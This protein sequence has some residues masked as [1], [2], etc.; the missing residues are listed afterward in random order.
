MRSK[1][2]SMVGFL[3][4]LSTLTGCCMGITGSGFVE[5]ESREVSGFSSI[6]FESAGKMTVRQT[7]K[8]SLIISADDNI[9]PLL[10]S[11]VVGRTLYL[12]STGVTN[13]RPTETIEFTV[14]VENLEAL[15]VMGAG[16]VEATGIRGDRL[17]VAFGGAGNVTIAG[18]V[19]TLELSLSGVGLFQGEGLETRWATV[20]HG[21]VGKAVVNVDEALD[22]SVSGIGA[23]EYIGSPEVR[24]S[25]SGLGTINQR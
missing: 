11:Y 18:S 4:G 6:S 10:E 1:L 24:K 3:A 2:Y 13:L 25:V 16:Y 21:G 12:T 23:V 22:V 14:E 15:D 5:T 19:D 20:R 9:L 17:S 7:G 8:E